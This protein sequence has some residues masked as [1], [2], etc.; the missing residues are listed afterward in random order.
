MTY[1]YSI[2]ERNRIVEEYLP[3]IDETICRNY[4]LIEAA[5]LDRDDVYQQLAVRLIYA[6]M[7]FDPESGALK[8][9]IM[10]QL[11]SEMSNCKDSCGRDGFTGVLRDLRGV[12]NSP[13]A[14][15]DMPADS[16]MAA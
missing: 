4:V 8:Q 5:H 10:N 11:Q 9:H 15:G 1:D 12:V 13:S 14:C 6:V 16:L 7:S 2:A 3:C